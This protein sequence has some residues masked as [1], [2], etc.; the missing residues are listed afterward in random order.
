[1]EFFLRRAGIFLIAILLAAFFFKVNGFFSNKK[2]EIIK[3]DGLGYYSYLPAIFIYGDFTQNFVKAKVLKYYKGSVVPEYM[4]VID[5]KPVD[6]YFF[7]TAVLMYPFFMTAHWLSFY[8]HQPSDGYSILYQYFIGLSAVFYIF[9]GIFFCDKLLRLYGANTF[10]SMLI[11]ALLV[12]GTNIFFYAVVEPTM[13]HAFSFAMISAFLLFSKKIIE[14]E[15]PNYIIPVFLSLALVILIRPFNIMIILALPFLAGSLNK[16]LQ[17]FRFIIQH[18]ILTLSGAMLAFFILTLQCIIWYKQCGK[19]LVYSYTYERFYFDRPNI[20]NVLISYQKGFF[21]YTPLFFLSLIGFVYLF[22][23]NRFAAVTLFILLLFLVYVM[24]CWHQW[25]YGASFGFRPL[26]DYF[27]LFA[28][29]LLFSLKFFRR[30]IAKIIFIIFC[31]CTLLINQI[32]A[33]QY[34]KFILHWYYMSEYK[35]WRVFLRT[36]EQWN[37]YVWDNPEPADL[38]GKVV[39]TFG[40]DFENPEKYWNGAAQ[41]N[42]GEKAHSGKMVNCLDSNTT[43]SNTLI[44]TSQKE[45]FACQKPALI[46]TGY[47]HDNNR[48]PSYNLQLIVSYDKNDGGNYFYK[49]RLVDNF[50]SRKNGWKRFEI[51]MILDRLNSE[52]DGIKIYFWNSEKKS[53]FIDD[54][55]ISFMEQKGEGKSY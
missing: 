18:F 28:L 52:S 7:G 32:Q 51:A 44:L 12:F 2:S 27:A 20:L 17:A 14:H 55:N 8:F 37:G 40:T 36:N 49:P 3:S 31:L 42:V 22:R 1:M 50:V 6:K 48:F 11:C 39:K 53:F 26:I 24:S 21:I 15:D 25:F 23:K 10:Q 45:I 35:F 34:R 47:I 9:L 33:Y 54:V 19:F 30:K 46:V 16:L 5:N 38:I 43:F 41:L 29:L 4:Q 13:S